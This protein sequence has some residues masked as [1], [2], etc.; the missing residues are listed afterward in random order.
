LDSE[1]DF[2]IVYIR[3]CCMKKSLFLLGLSSFFSVSCGDKETGEDTENTSNTGTDNDGD[4]VTV[5]D[6]DCND[7]DSSIYPGAT[8]DFS[9]GIDQDCDGYA[10]V[11]NA[12]CSADFTITF[13][14]EETV[15]LNFCEDW[16]LSSTYEYDPDNPPELNSV[17]LELNATDE[18]DFDCSITLT[19]EGICGAG[20]YRQG[21]TTGNTML[22]TMDCSGVSDEN[23]GE[24]TFAEG[25]LRI[26]SINTGSDSGSFSGQ[27]LVTGFEGTL[28][29]WNDGGVDVV[30]AIRVFAEQLAGDEEENDCSVLESSIVDADSDGFISSYFDGDDCDDGDENTYPGA[31]ELDSSVDCMKDS[32]NDGYGSANVSSS[33]V[34]GGDC[35]DG[36]AAIN[37]GGEEVAFDGV[38]GDCDPLTPELN[39]I[40]IDAGLWH[41]CAIESSGSLQCWGDDSMGQIPPP[42]GTFTQVS[43]GYYHTCAIDNG[44][45]IQ[46][47]GEDFGGQSSGWQ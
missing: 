21:V 10:D 40:Q 33:V 29:V 38:D 4:G 34:A 37:Q 11:G 13:D 44:G 2:L 6:G 23:E 8:E 43:A 9:D 47:W 36:D 17:T 27:P 30:G 24:S 35:N 25:Y 1:L 20:Y 39:L 12:D 14:N 28:H 46:C 16:S 3:K 45:S 42:S 18:V 22:A 19:Q 7:D 15:E 31:A 26:D 32:D 41:S 5:E